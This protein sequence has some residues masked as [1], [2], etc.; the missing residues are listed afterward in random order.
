[1]RTASATDVIA[2]SEREFYIAAE[3]YVAAGKPFLR[4]TKHLLTGT[5]WEFARPGWNPSL[6]LRATPDLRS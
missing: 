3:A 5:V 2:R 4:H 6:A 1:M